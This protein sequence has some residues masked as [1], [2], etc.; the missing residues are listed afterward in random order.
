MLGA[1]GDADVDDLTPA[2][3]T[4]S[5]T[6]SEAAVFTYGHWRFQVARLGG[7]RRARVEHHD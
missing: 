2:S 6:P 1:A 3:E 7:T 4:A 5:E